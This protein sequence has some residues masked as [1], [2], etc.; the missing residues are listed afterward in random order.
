MH[1]KEYESDFQS[2]GMPETGKSVEEL[3][4]DVSSNPLVM[5]TADLFAGSIVDVME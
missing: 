3:K 2:P 4:R 1:Q 5:E